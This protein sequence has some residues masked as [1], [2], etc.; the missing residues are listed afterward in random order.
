MSAPQVSLESPDT[1]SFKLVH[2]ADVDKAVAYDSKCL[3][4]GF[5][6][7]TEA[8]HPGTCLNFNTA[9]YPN[10][11][12]NASQWPDRTDDFAGFQNFCKV[13]SQQSARMRVRARVRARCLQLQ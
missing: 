9:N 11:N 4:D 2:A 1:E 10:G 12:W 3:N 7:C 13:R 8:N 5:Y 6:Y